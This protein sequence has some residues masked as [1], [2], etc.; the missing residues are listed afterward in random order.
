M[1]V[2]TLAGLDRE[3]VDMTTVLIVGNS[4]TTIVGDRVV[5]PRGYSS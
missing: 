1:A 4:R 5:T 3:A 2:E